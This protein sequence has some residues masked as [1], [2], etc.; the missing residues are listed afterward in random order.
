VLR[1]SESGQLRLSLRPSDVTVNS[2]SQ[3]GGR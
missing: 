3:T 2:Q 1:Y